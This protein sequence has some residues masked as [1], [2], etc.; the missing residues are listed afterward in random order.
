METEVYHLVTV[1]QFHFSDYSEWMSEAF[2]IWFRWDCRWICPGARIVNLDLIGL[3]KRGAKFDSNHIQK[4]GG[5]A[6]MLFA[7]STFYTIYLTFFLEQTSTVVL[8]HRVA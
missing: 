3:D 8:V 7:A 2:I 5:A 4:T 6:A 1:L